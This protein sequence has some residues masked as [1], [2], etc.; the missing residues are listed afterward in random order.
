M[1]LNSLNSLFKQRKVFGTSLG[2]NFFLKILYANNTIA[3][4]PNH[5]FSIT[6][7]YKKY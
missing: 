1:L 4:L 2:L 5:S 7:H 6:Q 3:I